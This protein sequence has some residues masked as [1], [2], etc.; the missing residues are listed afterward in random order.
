M[1]DIPELI[2]TPD[3]GGFIELF[4]FDLTKYDAGYFR[5]IKGDEGASVHAVTWDGNVYSPWPIQTEGWE[6]NG[7]GPN[8]RPSIAL[9]NTSAIL[10]PIVVNN[11]NLLGCVVKRIRT[12]ERYLDG[13]A[14]ADTS[15]TYPIETYLINQ[16]TGLN[17]EVVSFELA[18]Y[19]DQ[20]NRKLPGRQI[21]REFCPFVTRTWN[22][23]SFDY[24]H[25]TCPYTGSNY[26]DE[27]G[28]TVTNPQDEK[29]SKKLGTCCKVRF[30]SGELPFGGFPGVARVRVK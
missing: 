9:G 6:I 5:I 18:S 22:G 1:P 3:L 30:P 23:T 12:Y 25:T 14:E 28:D 19:L 15:Q 11:N 24:E 16:R 13:E 27:N 26:F 2:Q 21:M 8:P 20:E 17:N 7:Q 10:T 4:E 29:Y